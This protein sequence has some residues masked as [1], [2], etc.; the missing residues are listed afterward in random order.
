M[1]IATAAIADDLATALAR[2]RALGDA[3]DI[4]R[5]QHHAVRRHAFEIGGDEIF[6][7]DRGIFLADAGSR[8]DR[9]DRR[10]QPVA[11]DALR[12]GRGAGRVSRHQRASSSL[13][14]QDGRCG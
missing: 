6:R 12:R 9:G 2:H 10:G 3:L 4:H 11:L 5:Q 13:A 7:H 1:T 8:E 14:Y